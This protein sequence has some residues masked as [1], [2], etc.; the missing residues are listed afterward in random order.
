VA[1]KYELTL[2]ELRSELQGV[3]ELRIEP[4]GHLYSHSGW[5]KEQVE[6]S[7]IPLLVPRYIVPVNDPG[8]HRIA[9]TDLMSVDSHSSVPSTTTVFGGL[10]ETVMKMIKLALQVWHDHDMYVVLA[11]FRGLD[12]GVPHSCSSRGVIPA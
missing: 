4:R 1:T 2:Q 5:E 10:S 12:S 7:E 6:C 11:L 9:V 8:Q 3:D